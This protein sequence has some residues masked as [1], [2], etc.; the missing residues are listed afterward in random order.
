MGFPFT[1]QASKSLWIMETLLKL[2]LKWDLGDAYG[3]GWSFVVGWISAKSICTKLIPCRQGREGT[4]PTSKSKDYLQ[5][6]F[7]MQYFPK[8]SSNPRGMRD[9]AAFLCYVAK[10]VTRQNMFKQP[11]KRFQNTREDFTV[12]KLDLSFFSL[13][14]MKLLILF[15]SPSYWE[16]K[17]K[18]DRL[19]SIWVRGKRC[20][21]LWMN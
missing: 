9:F 21:T 19:G 15:N 1:P 5:H 8:S 7:S 10:S 18:S 4:E 17:S 20:T 2:E 6:F 11:R 13:T 16:S 14:I 3:L 12:C